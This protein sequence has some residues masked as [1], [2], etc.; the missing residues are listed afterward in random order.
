MLA[1]GGSCAKVKRIYRINCIVVLILVEMENY[2]ILFC[3]FFKELPQY[4]I[5][6]TN[7]ES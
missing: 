7:G 2:F 6:E 4:K 5:P 3:T 1:D